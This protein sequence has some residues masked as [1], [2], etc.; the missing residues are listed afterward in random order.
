MVLGRRKTIQKVKE[1][2]LKIGWQSWSTKKD[3]WFKFPRYNFRPGPQTSSD[4]LHLKLSQ[5]SKTPAY[6]WCS[7]YIHGT[8]IDEDKILAQAN[9]IAKNP[10]QPKLPLEYLLIDD[11]WNLWGDWLDSDPVKFPHGLPWVVK[12]I[13]KIG[14]KSGVWIAPFL[15]DPHSK[16]AQNHP[17]W[18]VRKNGHLVE[19]HN[20]SRWDKFFS[21]KKWLLDIRKQEVRKYVNDSLKYLI[22]DCGFN[23]LKLDFL[24]ALHFNPHLKAGEADLFLRK[25]LTKIKKIYPEVYTIACGCPL[26]PAAGVVDSMRIGPDTKVIHPPLK[27]LDFPI[28]NRWYLNSQVLPTLTQKLWTKKIWNVD[29]DAFLCRS[30]L[31]YTHHQL[32]KF[33]KIIKGGAGN[34]FLGDDLTKLSSRR[35]QK[36]LLPLFTRE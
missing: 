10:L 35:I 4:D 6:G 1:K 32:I 13:K 31:G 28:I 5:K 23:L 9:W 21:L 3:S 27:F 18:L 22:D 34:I 12:K 29:P 20:F 11:G 7:W 14:L 15:V 24:Y 2:L 33:Q 36:Y 30:S 8:N 19:G 26:I 17:D 25:Y 16:L